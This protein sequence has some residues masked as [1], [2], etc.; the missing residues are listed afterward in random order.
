MTFFMIF[1]CGQQNVQK[2]SVEYVNAQ[3]DKL[4]PVELECDLSNLS[5]SDKKVLSKLVQAGKIIDELFLIQ[6][7]MEYTLCLPSVVCR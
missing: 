5:D 2:E 4:A 7:V 6:V 3:L 1:G